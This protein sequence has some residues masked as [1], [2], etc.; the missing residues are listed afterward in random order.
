MPLDMSLSLWEKEKRVM[1]KMALF[2]YNL[3]YSIE[4]LRIINS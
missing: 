2:G 4:Y 3:S 1:H